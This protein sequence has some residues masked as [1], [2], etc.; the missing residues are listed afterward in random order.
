MLRIFVKSFDEVEPAEWRA[1]YVADDACGFKLVCDHDD[2]VKG[3]NYA[4][5]NERQS[6]RK[7]RRKFKER[8]CN[9]EVAARD[10]TSLSVAQTAEGTLEAVDQAQSGDALAGLAMMASRV[11]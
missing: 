1:L 9:A 3:F 8:N 2:L 7:L 4:L 6:N 11:C 5:A 10:S